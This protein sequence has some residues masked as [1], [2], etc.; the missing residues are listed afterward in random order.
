MTSRR[1]LVSILSVC[2]GIA[3]AIG[4]LLTFQTT[5]ERFTFGA[6]LLVF[7]GAGSLA[8]LGLTSCSGRTSCDARSIDLEGQADTKPGVSGGLAF[9]RGEIQG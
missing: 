8:F 1:F 4:D 7:L 3:A 2:A 9:V 5:L 6:D